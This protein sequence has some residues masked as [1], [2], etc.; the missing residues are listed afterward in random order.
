MSYDLDFYKLK[1]RQLTEN[2]IGAYLTN[3]LTPCSENGNEWFFENE[4]TEVYFFL[5]RNEPEDNQEAIEISEKFSDFDNTQ[6]TFNL[7]F[8]RPNRLP[9]GLPGQ[10]EKNPSKWN[11]CDLGQA[12]SGF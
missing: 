11:A 1:G 9:I 5:N 4:D 6:F 2:E 8:L 12:K 3:N 7:N 10:S